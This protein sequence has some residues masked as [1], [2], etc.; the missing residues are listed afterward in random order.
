[1]KKFTILSY[2][3]LLGLISF[4]QNTNHEGQTDS[5]KQKKSALH[6]TVN[7]LQ[8]KV[9]EQESYIDNDKAIMTRQADSIKTI[10]SKI[11]AIQQGYINKNNNLL[12]LII[13]IF[14]FLLF[15]FLY[16]RNALKRKDDEFIK[17]INET[18]K[19]LLEQGKMKDKEVT[20]LAKDLN[21][22]NESIK[23]IKNLINKSVQKK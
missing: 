3:F 16:F 2:F 1:M 8:T 4:A 9:V 19:I 7:T 21:N 11:A 5:L 10:N 13:G 22:T 17:Y 14:I 23:E 20:S 15:I 12:A 6:E 18:N